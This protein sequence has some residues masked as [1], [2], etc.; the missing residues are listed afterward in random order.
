MS[1]IIKSADAGERVRPFATGI[2]AFPPAAPQVDPEVSRL[3]AEV[4]RL[5]QA[6]ETGAER[7]DRLEADAG[8]TF[9]AGRTAGFEA[10]QREGDNL[11]AESLAALRAGLDG[12][13]EAF[14]SDM[15]ALNGL[16]VLVARESLA[17]L[18]GDDSQR[19]GLV[20]TLLGQQLKAL[21]A[22]AVVRIEVSSHD[23][24]DADALNA[25]AAS[26]A[27]PAIEVVAETSLASGD[28]RIRLKL[29]SLD[30]GI[31]QQWQGLHALLGELAL[32]E[33][34]P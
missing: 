5:R 30:V 34:R 16:A 14:R 22:A 33:A 12:A 3:Q 11:R 25:L 4:A 24:A 29:G 18:V 19:Q 9:E 15:A 13:L 28:C 7:I 26:V 8:E 2:A 1:A 21:E 17:R 27:N 32:S 10:G 6:L 20:T 31:D 23:F